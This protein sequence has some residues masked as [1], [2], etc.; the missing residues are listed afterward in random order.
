MLD[1]REY[2]SLTEAARRLGVSEPVLR[3]RVLRGE[4]PTF[5][6]PADLRSRLIK[7]ADVERYAVPQP[8]IPVGAGCG[9]GEGAMPA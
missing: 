6:N 9:S 4:L 3:R 5:T 8:V 7:A 2:L 1:K